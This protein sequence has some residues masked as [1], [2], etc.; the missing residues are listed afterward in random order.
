MV[1]RPGSIRWFLAHDLRVTW[2]TWFQR[3]RRK[4]RISI[5]APLIAITV[6]LAVTLA[7]GVPLAIAIGETA[8]VAT[9]I[10]AVLIGG[11]FFVIFT[12]MMSQT[13]V[14]AVDV[15]Y[16]RGD[17]DLLLSSPISPTRI[18]V[19]RAA[20]MAVNPALLFGGMITPVVLPLAILGHPHILAA[21]VVIVALALSA[22]AVDLAI[23]IGLF[24]AIGP[25][26]TRTAAQI[27][28]AIVG[29]ALVIV[30]IFL[31][32][33][34]GAEDNVFSA[35]WLNDL[36]QNDNLP[37]L[38]SVPAEAVLGSPGP[39]AIIVVFALSAFAAVGLWVG[40]RFSRDAAAA[41]RADTARRRTGRGDARFGASSLRATI[42][43]ELRL[44][45]RDPGL[46]SQ[47]VLRVVYVIPVAAVV[48]MDRDDTATIMP[49]LVAGAATLLAGQLAGSIAW[50]TLSA[51]DAP[52]FLATS[53]VPIRAFWRAKLAVATGVPALL[54]APVLVVLALTE[55]RAAMIGLVG[56]AASAGSAALINL[57]LQKPSR[58][59]EYR[60]AMQSNFGATVLELATS[61]SFAATAG[62]ATAG[63]VHAWIPLVV[64]VTVPA[65]A[66]RSE[67]AIRERMTAAA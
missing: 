7:L 31:R 8:I 6:V 24:S 57:W 22:T 19:A 42:S 37:A 44:L 16:E 3:K 40:R 1:F 39:L 50:I 23:A 27:L 45:L 59:T 32:S 63:L 67:G 58:R 15:F 61:V 53:P 10:V 49:F 2:R 35:A 28:A 14:T 30:A 5:P 38:V 66:Y 62:L 21:Y 36:A 33:F 55:P 43:K 51:E 26:G 9:P 13:F 12:L 4:R 11:A 29:A 52:E 65:L 34:E 47:V 60:R 20:A 25:R 54:I 46:I 48:L 64:A 56:S 18:L 41:N 17:L